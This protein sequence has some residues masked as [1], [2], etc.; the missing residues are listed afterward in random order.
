MHP[1]Y[2]VIFFT[3][4]TGAGYGLLAPFGLAAGFGL[5]PA[6]VGFALRGTAMADFLIV[7]GWPS[8]AVHLWPPDRSW[9]PHTHTRPPR[10][11]SAVTGSS[12][13]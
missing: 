12:S 4:A 10:P 1:A 5:L 7:A 2:S 9:V 6:D 13:R 8:C 3:T 11:V